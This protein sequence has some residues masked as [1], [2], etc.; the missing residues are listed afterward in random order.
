MH[1]VEERTDSFSVI[2]IDE[3]IY[4][5]PYDKQHAI[6][7]AKANAMLYVVCLLFKI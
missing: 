1:T 3:L 4:Y 2:S 7:Y 6:A 5:R